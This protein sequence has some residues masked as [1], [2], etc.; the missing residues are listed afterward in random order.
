MF[1][2]ENF[3]QQ[4][5]FYMNTEFWPEGKTMDTTKFKSVTIGIETWKRLNEIASKDLR[6]V[7]R[8]IEYLVHEHHY[9]E[10]KYVEG[11][12]DLTPEKYFKS[13]EKAHG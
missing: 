10:K 11:E 8:T 12:K 9:F 6:S 4:V 3:E 2:F 5:R 1:M 7:S 13:Q